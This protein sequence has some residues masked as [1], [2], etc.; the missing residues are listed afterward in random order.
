MKIA[1][2][3]AS[4]AFDYFKIGGAESFNR[5]LATGLIRGGHRADLSSMEIRPL[6]TKPWRHFLQST[7][8]SLS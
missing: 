1:F 3:G 2:F 7:M 5:R 4:G 6:N 8:G